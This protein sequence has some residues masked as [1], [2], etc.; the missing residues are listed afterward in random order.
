M[1]C[2][3]GLSRPSSLAVLRFNTRPP[4]YTNTLS[5]VIVATLPWAVVVHLIM[6]VWVYG[7]SKVLDS[8]LLDLSQVRSASF[9]CVTTSSQLEVDVARIFRIQKLESVL[10][11]G[12]GGRR[13]LWVHRATRMYGLS[14]I[15]QTVS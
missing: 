14:V 7:N 2:W 1:M 12:G 5:S 9:L 3:G 15:V 8:G 4:F 13:G 10:R 11:H 6:A